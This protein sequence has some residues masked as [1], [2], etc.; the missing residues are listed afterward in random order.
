MGSKIFQEVDNKEEGNLI[1]E[2]RWFIGVMC[3]LGLIYSSDSVVKFF[4]EQER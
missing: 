2:W 3:E 1:F 4:G